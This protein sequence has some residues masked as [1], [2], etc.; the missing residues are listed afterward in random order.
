MTKTLEEELRTERDIKYGIFCTLEDVLRQAER[1]FKKAKQEYRIA[2][3]AYWELK[4]PMVKQQLK[5]D[6]HNEHLHNSLVQ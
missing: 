4:L 2:D 5:E 6:T 1:Q 3:K